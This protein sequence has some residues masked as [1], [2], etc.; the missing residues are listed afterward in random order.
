MF[1]LG[2]NLE[3]S[4]QLARLLRVAVERATE[5]PEIPE[6]NDVATLMSILALTGHLPFKNYQ[7]PDIQKE[8]L[9]ELKKIAASPDYGF[10]LY[11]CFPA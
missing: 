10:G 7:A 4:E 11:F 2:R 5:G 9:E 6:P 8:T 3:R 1:W